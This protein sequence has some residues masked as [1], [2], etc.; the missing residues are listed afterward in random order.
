[1]IRCKL[2]S[3]LLIVCSVGGCGRVSSTP[4]VSPDGLLEAVPDTTGELAVTIKSKDGPIL[5]RWETGASPY[6]WWVVEWKD[7]HTLQMASGDIGAYMLERQ[8]DNTWRE[9]TPGMVFSP[10]GKWVASTSWESGETKKLRIWFGNVQ[11]RR[12]YSVGGDFQTDFV[13]SDPFNCAHWNGNDRVIVK[14]ADGERSWMKL[15]DG[16]WT[17]EN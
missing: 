5:Y 7:N 4:V 3:T 17:Y 14:A 13:I 6:Q 10:D 8:P 11:G 2:L 15:E 1:M 9:S 12:S 16:T